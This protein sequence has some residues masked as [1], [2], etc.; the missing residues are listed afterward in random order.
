M[1][2]CKVGCDVDGVLADGFVPP[3][4]DFCVI[5]GRTTDEWARTVAKV[6]ASRPIY[7]RPPNFPGEA[8]VWKATVIRTTG[9]TRFYEDMPDQARDIRII[10]PDCVVVLV[11][12]GEIVGVLD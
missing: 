12:Q 10:C 8:A 6:G 11:K 3:E 5:S 9:I 7:L 1:S 4:A 2:F